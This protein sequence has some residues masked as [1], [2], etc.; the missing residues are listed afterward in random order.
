MSKGSKIVWIVLS[1]AGALAVIVIGGGILLW[2]TKGAAWK[3]ELREGGAKVMAEA[4]QAG[5][6]ATKEECVQLALARLRQ[7][8]GFMAQVMVGIFTEHCL[9]AAKGELAL[10]ADAPPQ[11]E[12]LKTVAWRLKASEALGLR[13]AENE[14]VKGIQKHCIK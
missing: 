2:N 5:A 6:N 9:D 4:A 7:D 8:S 14:V 1:V 3:A 10:C 12:I 13:D 11:D